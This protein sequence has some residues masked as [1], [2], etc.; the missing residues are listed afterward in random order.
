VIA[1]VVINFFRASVCPG[2]MCG[3]DDQDYEQ[4][5]S[6]EHSP[7]LSLYAGLH[8]CG[9]TSSKRKKISRETIS[10]EAKDHCTIVIIRIWLRQ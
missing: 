3:Q 2:K 7:Q 5:C 10:Y 9:I 1:K 4:S 8:S 6:L